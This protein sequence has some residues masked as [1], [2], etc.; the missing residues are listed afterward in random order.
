MNYRLHCD[1]CSTS[2]W[3]AD[4]LHDN[5]KCP[6]CGGSPAR[7]DADGAVYCWLH[8]T[9]MS[10]C[11]GW[12]PNH[13]FTTYAWSGQQH[14]FPNA[15]LFAAAPDDRSPPAAITPFCEACQQLLEL[16]DPDADEYA[17]VYYRPKW[18]RYDDDGTLYVR[19]SSWTPN[20]HSSGVFQ[21]KRDHTD[22]GF[23][24]WLTTEPQYN[25]SMT[26]DDLVDARAE[27]LRSM[28]SS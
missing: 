24:R 28:T 16:W 21:I 3:E 7:Y 8:R 14:R 2:P 1:R 15:K 25:R 5:L 20:T 6:K 27:F 17:T 22:Y 12:A 4:E 13:L 9:R 23:W 19:T 18:H 11:Y 26:D 10:Q